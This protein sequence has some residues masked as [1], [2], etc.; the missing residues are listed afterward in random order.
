MK[1][2]PVF[3]VLVAILLAFS[4]VAYGRGGGGHGDGPHLG[5]GSGPSAQSAGDENAG[6][7]KKKGDTRGNKGGKVRGLE[8]ADEVAGEH[9]DKGRDT[10]EQRQ[11]GKPSGSK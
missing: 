9:G 10:A 3:A 7:G 1:I 2:Y 6:K 8:R 4:P 5:G 11:S